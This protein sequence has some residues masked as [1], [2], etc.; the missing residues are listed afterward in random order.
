MNNLMLQIQ[1]KFRSL[2]NSKGL[3]GSLTSGA[4]LCLLTAA[5]PVHA[6]PTMVIP[7]VP[8]VLST[9]VHPQVLIAV[10]NSQSMDGTLSGAIMTGS[11]S[12]GLL[13]STLDNTSSPN[14]YVVPAGFTP[15]VQAA[16][17]SGN[18]PYTV[19]QSGRLVDNGPSR[20]NTAKAGIDAIIDAY[21]QSTDFG[22]MVYS[23]SGAQV[24]NTW[25]YYMSPNGADFDATNTPVAGKRYVLNPCYN[26][27]LSSA[28][29]LANCAPIDGQI[30]GSKLRNSLYLEI[31]ASSDDPSI[32]D[33]L[34]TSSAFP[35]VFLVYDGPNPA[36][37]YPPNYSLANYNNGSVVLSYSKTKPNV[38]GLGTSPTNAGYVPFSEQ[39]LFAQRGFGYTG[40]QSATTGNIL[41]PMTSAGTIPNATTV[42]NAI[43]Q[44]TPYLKPE[45]N[46]T[47]T[48]EIKAI[49]GQSP[50]AGLLSRA[51]TYMSTLGTTSGNGCPQKKYVIFISDGLP[52]QDLNGKLW[53][54]LG[55][56][57]AAGYGVTATFNA[58]GS[59]NA[60]NCKALSD[61]IDTIKTMKNNGI[62]T[63]VIGLGAGVDPSLNPQAAASLRA[64]AIAGGTENYYPAT[65]PESLVTSL[66]SILVAIQNGSF[67]TS[68]ASVSS[69]LLNTESVEYQG[70]FISN[71]VPYQDWTG[72]LS[73]IDLDPD[74]GAP[75]TSI[76]WSAKPLLDAK[77][78]GLG[79]QTN[80]VISTYNPVSKVGVPFQ[81]LNLSASQQS[82]LQPSDLL[83]LLRLQYIRGNTLL[84]KRFGGVF[85]NRSH[86]L[87]DIMDSQVAHV[88]PPR[89]A[90]QS[91]SYQTFATNQKNR[92]TMLYVGANDGML[93][94][95]NANTGVEAFAFIPN[96]VFS[97]LD[98]F[99]LPTYNQSHLFFVNGSPTEADVQFSDNSWH[100]ILVGGENGG[101]KSIYALDITNPGSL[102]NE[103]ALSQAVLWE[104]TDT[105]LG[106]TYSQPQ[107]A[108]T[109]S[110]SNPFVVFFGNGYNS[111][112]NKSV[113]YA[114]N[115]QT[116]AIVREIDL[117]AAVPTA[118]N[119]TLP[120]G[121]SSV[122]IG[123]KD[124]L[125]G[126]PI[127]TVYAGDLQGNL[128][129]IDVSNVDPLQWAPRLLFQARDSLGNIQAITTPPVVTLNPNYP[130]KQGIF[131]MFGT[132]RLLT[133]NDLVDSQK[134]TIYGVWDKPLN[135]STYT[136]SNLQSQTLNQ[137]SAA[138]AGSTA[139]ILTATS[140]TVNW[141]TKVGWFADLPVAGQ[142]TVT[143]PDLLNGTFITTINTPPL[144]AC[145]GTFSSML[146]ELNFLTGGANIRPFI[147]I[148]GDG[149]F[150]TG[151]KYDGGYAVGI[152][153]GSTY[154]NA[155]T[156]IGPNKDNNM[157]L[158][159]TKS[160]GSQATILNPNTWPRKIGWWEIQ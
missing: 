10:G 69:T 130:R 81:W 113:F 110:T 53:P 112:N 157:V 76:N 143:V 28:T 8:L 107:A 39:V 35:G 88:G 54:P 55:S 12:L 34:Y 67:S 105:D 24:R 92:Q 2:S 65:N 122:A 86:V 59:L 133:S 151:D 100:T 140:N 62:L 60:T 13:L 77:V 4:L 84:E 131:V 109:N 132:G 50:I 78:S 43:A 32:N 45:T 17:G 126:A 145:G 90:Y 93:H 103:S 80:R 51:N 147:D 48:S 5:E 96:A 142:R 31:S 158:L 11:G 46:S 135:V 87:G 128:W 16:D 70:S 56:A 82:A 144:A 138:V 21:M 83:G 25:V 159:I 97:N 149:N 9:T 7:Q 44:F 119:A 115:A 15:P 68:A 58:D 114:V 23:T 150:N 127:S 30:G 27:L 146:L 49:A 29:V 116:G 73:S 66:D 6:A 1:T 61:A 75:T 52:T 160:D 63:Y 134:Q 64:M 33:V 111:T 118:C 104:F 85:R 139:P 152:G 137:V 89:G 3:V 40:S 37:P 91:A 129:A 41:V 155:P 94:A 18:A 79:W 42:A 123:E 117:C 125:Q 19:T 101:G 47:S 95:F 22:L 141:N 136:R 71:D 99:T 57:S 148:N 102:T 124:G 74:T 153:L 20:L 26:Y 14:N 72:D 36:T 98:D 106:L 121:L 154:S 156:L 38:G 120:Q 108:Q